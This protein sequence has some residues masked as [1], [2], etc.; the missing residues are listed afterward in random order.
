[1]AKKW[2]PPKTVLFSTG[3]DTH[4]RDLED[5]TPWDRETTAEDLIDMGD[6]FKRTFQAG[7]DGNNPLE[8]KKENAD[9]TGQA[10][11]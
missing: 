1:M 10:D 7:A 5:L 9:R 8:R 4:E 2:L 6:R 11:N 3:C